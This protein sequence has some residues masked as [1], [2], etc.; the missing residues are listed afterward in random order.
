MNNFLI[1]LKLKFPNLTYQ[2]CLVFCCLLKCDQTNYHLANSLLDCY[3]KSYYHHLNHHILHHN[4]Q[5]VP[6]TSNLFIFKQHSKLFTKL[7]CNEI[8]IFNFTC[9]TILKTFLN[10]KLESHQF[11]QELL[12]ACLDLLEVIKF[13]LTGF[14]LQI[15]HHFR[16]HL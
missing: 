6:L 8:S 14:L 2:V 7:D 13:Q 4:H 10:N 15:N 3:R 5:T 1:A 12:K 11:F 9:V 16:F